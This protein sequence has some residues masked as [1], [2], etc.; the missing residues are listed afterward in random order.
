MTHY[1]HN[2][3]LE[4]FPITV[5]ARGKQYELLSAKGMFSKDDLDTGT[6]VLLEH[7][8]IPSEARVLDLGCGIGVVGIFV[9]L[10]N[11]QTT[12][13]QSDITENAITL[14]TLNAARVG[15]KTTAILSNVYESLQTQQFD[16]ILTNPPRAAG[17]KVIRDM[18]YGAVELLSVGG[19]LQLVA[20]TNKGG[21][22]YEAMM[23]EAFG[24]VNKIGRGSGFSVYRS[25]KY[26]PQTSST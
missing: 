22:S 18:I 15:V 13:V 16:V 25:M 6:R 10:W 14:A 17:K 4:T 23:Q 26:E 21:K 11:P 2:R 1:F 19:T 7:M 12:V 5:T 24:N 9:K 3:E 8:Q 20:M